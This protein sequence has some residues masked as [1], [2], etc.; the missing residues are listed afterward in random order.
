MA[1]VETV[2]GSILARSS[3]TAS[4]AM[5]EGLVATLHGLMT[6]RHIGRATAADANDEDA[7]PVP[8]HLDGGVSAAFDS[9]IIRT[10]DTIEGIVSDKRLWRP[11]RGATDKL[12]RA[13]LRARLARLDRGAVRP[14]TSMARHLQLSVTAEGRAC[15]FAPLPGGGIAGVGRTFEEAL[16]DFDESFKNRPPLVDAGPANSTPVEKETE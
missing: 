10:L 14:S 7:E 11:R 9:A 8:G 16:S 2:A 5:T 3:A 1:Q 15:V 13:D 6:A 4:A 12:T